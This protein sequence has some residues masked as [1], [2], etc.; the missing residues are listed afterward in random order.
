VDAR[1]DIF[2][3]TEHAGAHYLPKALSNSDESSDHRRGVDGFRLWHKISGFHFAQQ[4]SEFEDLP[5]ALESPWIKVI[6]A[7]SSEGAVYACQHWDCIRL[8]RH[9][10][11]DVH[12]SISAIG[13]PAIPLFSS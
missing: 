9:R 3:N 4:T 5:L 11:P 10:A 2:I 8:A 7:I 1:L 6:N 13:L 12:F